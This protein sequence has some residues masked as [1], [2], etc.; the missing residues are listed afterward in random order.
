MVKKD[1]RV[2]ETK[3]S[4][5][6]TKKENEVAQGH[7]LLLRTI[8]VKIEEIRKEKEIS[9]SELCTKVKV[10]RTTYYRIINGMVYFNTEKFLKIL[11]ILDADVSIK[12]IPKSEKE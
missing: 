2:S 9:V 5:K 12:L 1:K 7:K 11:D 4:Y 3:D 6:P 8:G 10:S